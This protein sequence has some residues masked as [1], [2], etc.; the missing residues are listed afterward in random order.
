[1]DAKVLLG[2]ALR[3]VERYKRRS[4]L[5]LAAIAAGVAGL[6]LS[7]GFVHD[8]IRQLGEAVIHS[9][10]GHLQIARA[11][12]FD[13]GS[14]APS[15]YLIAPADAQRVGLTDQAHIQATMR[16]INFSGLL[17]N[18]RSS[19]PIVGEGIEPDREAELGTSLVL[20]Q[21][22][23]LRA[24]DRYGALVGAGVARAL[25]LKPGS[26]VSIVAPT[27]DEAMNTVE[28]EVVGTFQSFSKDYDDRTI[29]I[30]L[31]V[32]QELL[33]TDGI[34]TIV[35]VLDDTSHTA[36]VAAALGPRVA[37]AHLE[38]RTWDSL[39]DF[40]AKAVALYDRQ[41]GVLRLIV[42][43]MVLLA[44]T[45][46]INVRVL[47]RAGEF[48]TM[49]SLGNRSS[50]VLW[51]VLAEGALMGALGALIGALLGSAAAWLVSYAG[52]PMPPP[53]NSNLEYTARI[54]LVPSVIAGAFLIGLIAT[55]LA[56]VAPAYRVS[57]L[58]IVEALRRLV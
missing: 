38:L 43:F 19:Y 17:S 49:R 46:A 33:N 5:S 44:V 42:L 36:Q 57:R 39:N 34:N 53:P 4:A 14:R 20:Q 31:P 15:K 1:M 25:D 26:L 55:V 12:F 22:R 24:A 7:G 58:P 35:V 32:A 29:K 47:E 18:G 45:G 21:G 13:S 3:N 54:M 11:G 51:L 30:P 10:S 6:I 28:V 37:D 50:D 41:F 27:V 2:L 9:Q 52:I 56:S 8:L 48:G 40:Y 23:M 16:R